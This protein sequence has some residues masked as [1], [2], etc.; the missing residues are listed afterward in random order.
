[1]GVTYLTLV[2]QLRKVVSEGQLYILYKQLESGF[3]L[4]SNIGHI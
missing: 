1:M 3:T 2:R 4:E